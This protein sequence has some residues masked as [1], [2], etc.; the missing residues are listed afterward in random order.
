M[1][2]SKVCG[3]RKGG[4]SLPAAMQCVLDE[5][6]GAIKKTRLVLYSPV[7]FHLSSGLDHLSCPGRTEES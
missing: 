1:L 6:G 2:G 3:K 4:T 7:R 5:V